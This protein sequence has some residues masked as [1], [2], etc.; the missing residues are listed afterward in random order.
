MKKYRPSVQGFTLV[1][2]M[3]TIAVMVI[4]S[5]VAVPGM[6]SFVARSNMQA[7][8]ND[9]VAT[10]NRA[11]A[12]AMARNAC[13]TVC[14]LSASASGNQCETSDAAI[15]NWHRGWMLVEN[16]ACVAPTAAAPL[17]GAGGRVL[18]VRQSSDARYQLIDNNATKEVAFTYTAR[19]VLQA[20]NTTLTLTDTA[21]QSLGANDRALIVN[22]HG[23][24]LAQNISVAANPTA[25]GGD[26]EPESSS[27]S[28]T[29]TGTGSG[30]GTGAGTDTSTGTGTGT[31]TGSTTG[32]PQ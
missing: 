19:G 10:M 17:P 1:E 24:V 6:Q 23:R 20:N 26:E 11:R 31:G 13:V 25:A 16:P 30:T 2:L 27:G 29:G 14:Q 4:L 22:A 18:A 7:L 8:Q 32:V 28:G 15:G 5:M 3:V 9:F 21:E 12:E